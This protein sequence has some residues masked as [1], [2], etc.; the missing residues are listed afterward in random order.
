MQDVYRFYVFMGSIPIKTPLNG[1]SREPVPNPN[2]SS[3]LLTPIEN[4]V[5]P[6][7]QNNLPLSYPPSV[8]FVTLSLGVLSVLSDIN[9]SVNLR[10]SKALDFPRIL[11]LARLLLRH[12]SVSYGN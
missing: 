2:Q 10:P 3:S 6:Y 8:Q 11:M 4:I 7:S 1:V 12:H 5:L 9:G